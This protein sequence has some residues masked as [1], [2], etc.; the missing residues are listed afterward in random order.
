[1]IPIFIITA[2]E[3]FC[4]VRPVAWLFGFS[5]IVTLSAAHC[6]GGRGVLFMLHPL[7]LNAMLC[8]MRHGFVLCQRL[9]GIRRCKNKQ[10]QSQTLRTEQSCCTLAVLPLLLTLFPGQKTTL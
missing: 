8:H 7:N 4:L 9:V 3:R 2:L 1:M 10:A 6:R 5:S